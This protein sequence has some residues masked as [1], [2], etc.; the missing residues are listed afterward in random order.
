VRTAMATGHAEVEGQARQQLIQDALT[1]ALSK[2][3]GDAQEAALVQDAVKAAL[4]TKPV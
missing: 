1:A 2:K 3:V 4:A